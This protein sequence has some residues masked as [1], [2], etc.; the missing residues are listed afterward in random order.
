[1]RSKYKV[2]D[3]L[4]LNGSVTIFEGRNNVFEVND[5]ESQ[6]ILRPHGDDPA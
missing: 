3:W 4:N 1:M 5:L 6:Q 2:A